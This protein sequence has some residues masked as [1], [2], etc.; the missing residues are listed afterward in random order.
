M[1]GRSWCAIAAGFHGNRKL[2]AKPLQRSC[3]WLGARVTG[4]AKAVCVAQRAKSGAC[5]AAHSCS[6]NSKISVAGTQQSRGPENLR[7]W[8]Y[9]WCNASPTLLLERQEVL[10]QDVHSFKR[11]RIH[12]CATIRCQRMVWLQHFTIRNYSVAISSRRSLQIDQ[13]TF[14]S[15]PLQDAG[16]LH[17]RWRHEE[18][19][20]RADSRRWGSPCSA[21]HA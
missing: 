15:K 12:G 8:Q 2:S 17:Q 1:V 16:H 10:R 6:S 7:P 9:L 11:C 19:R 3:T 13:T 5:V 4:R 20:V 21:M 18:G 14:W